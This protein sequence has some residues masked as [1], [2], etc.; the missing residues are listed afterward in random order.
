ML[1]LVAILFVLSAQG[2]WASKVALVIG[3][4]D[5]EHVS[6][7]PNPTND[8]N[9]TVEMLRRMGFDEVVLELDTDRR[10]LISALQSFADL[11]AGA[12]MAAVFYAGHGIEFG[13]ANYLIPTD[14][15][16]LRDR[17]VEFEAVPLDL[18]MSAV[19]GASRF[20]LVVLDACRNNPFRTRMIRSKGSSRSVGRGLA[21]VEPPVNTLVAYA[22]RAG[23]EAAD[24]TGRNSPFTEALLEHLPT[25]GID[26]RILFGRVRDSVV[27]STEYGQVPHV[28]GS[29][30]GD[31]FYLVPPA[32]KAPDAGRNKLDSAFW[33]VAERSN[34]KK[35]Y[36]LYLA[37]F[38]QGQHRSMAEK[39][40][41]ALDARIDEEVLIAPLSS[42]EEMV[43]VAK[44]KAPGTRFRDCP[45]CPEMV[46][47]PGGTFRIGS[48]DDEKGRGRDEG[49]RKE[50]EMRSFA[51]GVY[52]VTFD[53]W[54][55]CV[56]D[57]G[58]EG[59]KP[60]DEGW[61]QGRLPVTNVNFGD[62]EAYVAWLA[63]RTGERYRLPSEA[64]WEY[65][66]RGGTGSA[67]AFGTR[68]GSR[69]AN[70]G[71]MLGRTVEVGSYAANAFGLF[72]MH[73]NVAEWVLDC[74]NDNYSGL[75]A[76]GR[77]QSTGDCLTRPMRGGSA[78]NSESLL[79]SAARVPV[80]AD[81]RFTYTGF[82]VMRPL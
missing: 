75:S 78:R 77:P 71:Y 15:Q 25:P 7:L 6:R 51:I 63:K 1:A 79:R 76:D 66:A 38:P 32:E 65:A 80:S 21:E 2:A 14:A 27:A 73:G 4:G 39:R 22:A 43:D 13:G 10:A 74:W 41:A 45:E 52:E 36:E 37:Q 47:L 53:E 40:I 69:E 12:E 29:L 64:E 57:G 72:D 42:P 23:S 28:Y 34:E 30:G 46:V 8:A 56:E 60:Y 18:V 54:T 62:A 48:P 70:Y 68:I 82:R 58:C 20:R 44:I 16:L 55:A 5:Y 59:Y 49:P 31:Y 3:N 67:Y 50:L 35:Y 81:A 26:V 9:S 24:G 19:E 33:E 11:S 17:D 61:G